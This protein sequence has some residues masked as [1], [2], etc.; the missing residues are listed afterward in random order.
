MLA[1]FLPTYK[2]GKPIFLG[3]TEDGKPIKEFRRLSI[4][5]VQLFEIGFAKEELDNV[6][7]MVCPSSYITER[8]PV[9]NMTAKALRK[10]LGLKEAPVPKTI[11]PL[12]QPN[13]VDKAVAVIPIGTKEDIMFEGLEQI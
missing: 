12:L 9:L 6:L 1:Q 10:T 13:L 7:S 11:N 5:P 2:D 8:F 4:R 3:V